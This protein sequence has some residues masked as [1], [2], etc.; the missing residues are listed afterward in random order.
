[1]RVGTALAG[2]AASALLAGCQPAAPRFTEQDM[3]TVRG[4]FDSVVTDVRAANWT[5]WAARWAEDGRFHPSNG[6]A[7]VGRPTL[8]AWAQAFPPVES[9]SFANV[10]VAGESNLAHGTSAVFIKL[11]DL[12]PD[13]AKQLVVFRRDT[14]GVW[15]ILAVSVT[16]DLPLPQPAP[17]RARR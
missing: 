1:M 17:T 9:F 5:A 3:T 12:P 15:Q 4:L 14:S 11:R 8:L 16:S 13:T 2:L 7:I 10:Q 6:L